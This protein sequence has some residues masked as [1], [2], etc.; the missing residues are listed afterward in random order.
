M[1][2]SIAFVEA[3]PFGTLAGVT[4]GASGAGVEAALQRLDPT[5]AS[6]ARSFTGLRRVA[7]VG[8]RLAAQAAARAIGVPAFG[9]GV[10]SQGEPR[11]PA[12]LVAS[13]AHKQGLAIA[14]V[15][16]APDGALGVDL[17]DDM[18]AAREAADLVFDAEERASIDRRPEDERDRARV[19]GFALKEAVYKALAPGCGRTL[20][21]REARV[22]VDDAGVVSVAP[23]L[24]RGLAGAAVQPALDVRYA[25]R[26]DAV[27]AA[28][29]VRPKPTGNPI[30]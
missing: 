2:F 26:G 25:W 29:R 10:G 1:P 22:S 24:D 17:E 11:P 5:E 9:L 8:G 6:I 12:G 30:E 18:R 23:R 28:V 20:L 14:L 4:L 19:V 15:A 13:I 3:H 16:L 7:F 27:V 21:Y